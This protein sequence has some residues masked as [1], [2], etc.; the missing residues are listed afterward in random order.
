MA[1]NKTEK[2]VRELAEPIARQLDYELV[3]VEFV[4]EGSNRF[5]RIYIDKPDGIMI[6]DCQR[7]NDAIEPI[8]DEKDPIPDAYYLEVCSPGLD[9]PLKTDRDFEKY[10]G[11]LVEVNLFEALNGEKHYEGELLGRKD[12]IVEILDENGNKISFPKEKIS[13]IRRVIIF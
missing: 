4:K 12:G 6:D 5:L 9:R 7:M 10:S 1:E 13:I 3:D 11:E 8:L 2:F